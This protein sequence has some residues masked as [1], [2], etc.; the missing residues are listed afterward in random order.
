MCAL[1]SFTKNTAL[2][3]Q[4][5]ITIIIINNNN[6]NSNTCKKSISIKDDCVGS[7]EQWKG[8]FQRRMHCAQRNSR[9]RLL[10]KVKD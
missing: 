8:C 5:H 3:K 10:S 2:Y 9:M 7:T 4:K 6:N 1:Y